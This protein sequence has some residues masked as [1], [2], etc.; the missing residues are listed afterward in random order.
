MFPVDTIKVSN[1][2]PLMARLD[3]YVS[4]WPTIRSQRR[5]K[6]SLQAGGTR[7]ILEGCTRDG[8]R[9]YTST[10]LILPCLRA[11][12]D[13]FRLQKRGDELSGTTY[14]WGIDDLR[15]RFLHHARRLH[16]VAPT[17]LQELE[18]AAVRD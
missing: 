5:C 3:T 2:E 7:K 16:K 9:L 18:Y 1:S 8:F 6:P 14:D 12:K 11:S 17:T 15:P 13:L 4:E 10:R